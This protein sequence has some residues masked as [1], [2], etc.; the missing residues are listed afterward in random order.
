MYVDTCLLGLT[1]ETLSV[2]VIVGIIAVNSRAVGRN[3][4]NS[5]RRGIFEVEYHFGTALQP[6]RI[7]YT[8]LVDD[9]STRASVTV[10]PVITL[11]VML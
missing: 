8:G 5:R 4:L 2:Q 6:S 11:S 10:I 1:H 7:T 9:A 3:A